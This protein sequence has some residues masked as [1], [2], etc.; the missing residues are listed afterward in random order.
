MASTRWAAS[1]AVTTR[2]LDGDWATARAAS[3]SW[4]ARIT[5]PT[6]AD[7]RRKPPRVTSSSPSRTSSSIPDTTET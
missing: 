2:P 5:E 7:Q 1:S 6:A 3:T 4:G